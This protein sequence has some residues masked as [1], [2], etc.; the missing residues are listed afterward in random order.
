MERDIIKETIGR[1][2]QAI[3]EERG[4]T[5]Q[6]LA[7]ALGVDRQVVKTWECATRHVKA[8][9]LLALADHYD[10]TVDYLLGRDENPTRNADLQAMCH[11]TGLSELSLNRLNY[12]S[13]L[14]HTGDLFIDFQDYILRDYT[15][16]DIGKLVYDAV[17]LRDM[18][19]DLPIDYVEQGIEW[20][21]RHKLP[22]GF[23]IMEAP[24]AKEFS[25]EHAAFVLRD[26]INRFVEMWHGHEA[27]RAQMLQSEKAWR[28]SMIALY[29][30][31][32][33]NGAWE[34]AEHG[35]H[36]ED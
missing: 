29:E 5:Q 18:S 16:R 21:N 30:K 3:R 25:I 6:M 20:V 12:D 23:D 10:C 34:E 1:R 8:P 24:R 33:G 32:N 13:S 11:Y 35:E 17:C 2:I 14:E 15:M 27:Y 9:D 4:E 36:Q 22:E 28:D 31:H 7:D 19:K 26:A